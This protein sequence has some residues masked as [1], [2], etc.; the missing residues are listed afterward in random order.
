VGRY[1]ISAAVRMLVY[2]TMHTGAV[3]TDE[4]KTAA[5]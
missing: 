3:L 2:A 5:V 4:G 1:S